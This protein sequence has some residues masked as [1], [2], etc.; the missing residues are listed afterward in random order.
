MIDDA[1]FIVVLWYVA[2]GCVLGALSE[3]YS[4]T[5]LQ[6]CGMY[7]IALWSLWE[8][9][10]I[11]DYGYVSPEIMFGASG[12]AIFATGTIIKTY[13]WRRYDQRMDKRSGDAQST[14]R[15]PGGRARGKNI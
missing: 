9:Y 4:G 11:Y 5:V 13:L 7:L 15:R 12:M 3:C 6:R 1:I 8:A 14:A 10:L 2:L